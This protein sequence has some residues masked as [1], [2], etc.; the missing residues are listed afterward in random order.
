MIFVGTITV[1]INQDQ[2]VLTA[3]ADYDINGGRRGGGV[4]WR[5]CVCFLTSR[6]YASE[7][8][9]F[10]PY[11]C[12]STK[13]VVHFQLISEKLKNPIQREGYMRKDGTRI[14]LSRLPFD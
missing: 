2:V 9:L 7:N 3:T 6:I 12:Y 11:N 13:L 1:P 5:R 10:P 8:F 14:L 4:N